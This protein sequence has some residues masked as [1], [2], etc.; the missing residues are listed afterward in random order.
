MILPAVQRK[1]LL[2]REIGFPRWQ[3]LIDH[4]ILGPSF[5]ACQWP[6]DA[7]RPYEIAFAR[8]LWLMLEGG[9]CYLGCAPL[10]LYL[11]QP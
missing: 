6:S 3:R 8:V 2:A 10:P 7:T 4:R 1:N 9:R 5:I 11:P